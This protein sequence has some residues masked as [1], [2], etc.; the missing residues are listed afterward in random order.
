M[1]PRQVLITMVCA[2]AQPQPKMQATQSQMLPSAARHNAQE[3][4]AA[5]TNLCTL[6]STRAVA[7][8]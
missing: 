3:L 7:S 1:H 5:P 8:P 6:R 2:D 4:L